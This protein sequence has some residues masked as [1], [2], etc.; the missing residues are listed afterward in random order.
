LEQSNKAGTSGS[1][2][3]VV[4]LYFCCAC[5]ENLLSS[6]SKMP[7]KTIHKLTTTRTLKKAD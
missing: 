6:A 3:L 1:V 4:L 5:T 2:D 7:A